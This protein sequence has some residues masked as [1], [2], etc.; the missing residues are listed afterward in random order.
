MVS[1]IKGLLFAAALL[2]VVPGAAAQEPSC[3]AQVQVA[4]AMM[5]ELQAQVRMMSA[6]AARHYANTQ[7]LS[8]QLAT[9]NAELARLK[10]A[11]ED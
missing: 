6:R 8:A 1:Q 4:N 5:E 2:L 11:A 10:S 3:E 7:A 9:T